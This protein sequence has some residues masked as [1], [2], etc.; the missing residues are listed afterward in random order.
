MTKSQRIAGPDGICGSICLLSGPHYVPNVNGA[1]P[2]ADLAYPRIAPVLTFWWQVVSVVMRDP[3]SHAEV[4]LRDD[5]LLRI[6]YPD[7]G[8][9]MQVLLWW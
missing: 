8:L 5:L 2:H 3:D 6:V 9:V 7:G 4:V 1:V